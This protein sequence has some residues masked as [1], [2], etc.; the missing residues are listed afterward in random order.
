MPAITSDAQ[1]LGVDLLSLGRDLRQAWVDLQQS[2]WLSWLTPDAAV[3]LLQ[4]DGEESLWRAGVRQQG[5]ARPGS[6]VFQALQLPEEL[7]LLQTF[8]VPPMDTASHAA[9]AQL[10]ALACS[11][12]SE[13]DLVWDYRTHTD[14]NGRCQIDIALASRRQIAQYVQAQAHR[15][16]N[17]TPE[18]WVLLPT[19][20]PIIFAGYG[21]GQR[22]AHGKRGR[23]LRAGLLLL[24]MALAG[25]V[26]LT[27]TL[28]LRA[29]AIDAVHSFDA[30]ALRTPPLVH[31]REILLQSVEQLTGLSELL[32]GRIEPLRVLDRLTSVL[33][34]DTALQS[35]SLK[36]QKVTIT[37]LTD[38]ASSLMQLLGQQPGVRDVRAPSAAMRTAG[39]NSKESFVIEFA[40]DPQE[41]GVAVLAASPAAAP[42]PA[43]ALIPASPATA[44]SAPEPKPLASAGSGA[45]KTSAS[46]PPVDGLAPVFGGSP[47]QVTGPAKSD[48]ARKVK[49]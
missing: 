27:P 4:A 31:E 25:G 45:T 30:I 9:A 42:A 36:G 41:F 47:P 20:F 24:A 12:F 21:E 49:P 46:P 13:A 40:L 26:A 3:R 22:K 19:G 5:Q 38:N 15:L 35:F 23:Q 6:R 18:I 1:F 44:A 17:D 14:A 11:P 39:T 10:Q 16:G 8:T 2:R 43:T 29:R 28:Q 32:A 34:D 37:G 48:A 33:P 7:L